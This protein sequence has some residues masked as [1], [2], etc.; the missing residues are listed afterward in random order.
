M[1]QARPI[2]EPICAEGNNRCLGNHTPLQIGLVL[3]RV[4][5]KETQ[6]VWCLGFNLCAWKGMVC[7]APSVLL[8][9]G[10]NPVPQVNIPIPTKQVLKWVVNSPTP[11][12]D[13]IGF[14]P[15]PGSRPR[16]GVW[17]TGELAI[18]VH[19]DECLAEIL[20][21]RTIRSRGEGK[22]SRAVVKH[23]FLCHCGPSALLGH[24]VREIPLK[25]Q[26]MAPTRQLSTTLRSSYPC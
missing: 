20:S 7:Q 17:R 1:Q 9:M 21:D 12:W 19:R 8:A 10:Q 25:S 26:N 14:D 2:N 18:H 13:P 23:A 16:T 11:K 6:A 3:H 5:Q 24:C 22:N 4:L 15:T